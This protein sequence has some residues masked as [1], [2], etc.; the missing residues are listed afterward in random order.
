M[1]AGSA[2]LVS[3]GRSYKSPLRER[4]SEQTRAA[5]LEA[6]TAEL[7]EGGLHELNIPAIA[8]RAGVAVRTVYRYF[9]T[10]D[11]LLDAVDR[12]WD[13]TI[14]PGEPPAS[15]DEMPAIV[16][17]AFKEFDA[18]ETAMLAQWATALGRD[19]R[20]RGRRRRISAYGDVLSE[21]TSNLPRAEARAAHA[22]ISYLLSSL[23]W[24]TMREEFN[25]TGA[26]SGNAVAWA[27]RTLIEDLKIRNETAKQTHPS[28]L[29]TSDSQTRR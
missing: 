20:A 16:E 11:A 24:K 14:A 27:I 6:I 3:N 29:G 22:V 17:R 10:R 21:V 15:A 28:A 1:K 7:A 9:P 18:N 26:E 23:T 5:I 2:A 19:V 13:D 8:R 25:M 4:Q 12:W